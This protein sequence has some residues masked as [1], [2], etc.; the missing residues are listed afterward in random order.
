M[1]PE[2]VTVK[3]SDSQFLK[4]LDGSFSKEHRAIP[5]QS[6]NINTS[7]EQITFRVMPKSAILTP[8][9]FVM[10]IRLFRLE[11]LSLSVGPVL[12]TYSYLFHKG[13]E[14]DHL[15]SVLSLLAILLFHGGVFALN[16]YKD[17]IQ[18]VDR[19]NFKGGSQVI[20]K[21]WLSAQTVQR[22]G[23]MLCGFGAVIGAFFVIQ[24]PF[25]LIS[26]ALF[27]AVS[28]MAYSFWGN[29]LKT[30]GFGEMIS[31]FCFG[32]LLTYGFSRVSV[33][34]HT[35]QVVALGIPFGHLAALSLQVRHLE[36]LMSDDQF[37]V[38]TLGVRLGFD[39]YKRVIQYQF[40]FSIPLFLMG[41]Y[42][43][44]VSW[45][46]FLLVIP[47]A[48]FCIKYFR[49]IGGSRSTFSSELDGLREKMSELHVLLSTLLLVSFWLDFSSLMNH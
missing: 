20:Q 29:G 27:L 44:S 32:P 47:Y 13:F 25:F 43:S 17:H 33:M 34:D 40:L 39:R 46:N 23:I 15:N 31:F 42:L 21:G 18:G 30:L 10:L 45:I 49:I 24:Q 4:Y 6:L 19:I 3:K 14:I 22:L 28:V 1:S 16:D 37:R 26:A 36:N 8:N 2:F 7:R 11:W 38:T 35:W 48:Y 9:L 41:L 12:V 5:E